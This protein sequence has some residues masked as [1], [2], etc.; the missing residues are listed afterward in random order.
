[1]LYLDLPDIGAAMAAKT[2]YLTIDD[3]PSPKMGEKVDYLLRKG[4]PAVWFC[5]GRYLEQRPEAAMD[6][7]R[8]GFILGNHAYD[9]PRFSGLKLD[10]CFDQ[11]RR[12][13]GLIE[14]LYCRCG[15]KRPARWFRCLTS[16]LGWR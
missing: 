9:H 6:A 7:I 10:E 4:I 14:S 16:V 12:T 13:D 5:E 3:A 8:N 15:V 11:I 1:M 2:A